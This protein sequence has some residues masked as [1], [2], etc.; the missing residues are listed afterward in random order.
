MRDTLRALLGK[1]GPWGVSSGHVQRPWQVGPGACHRLLCC[2]LWS[3]Q[4]LSSS[5]WVTFYTRKWRV[6]K[7]APHIWHNVLQLPKCFSYL[8][9]DLVLTILFSGKQKNILFDRKKAHMAESPAWHPAAGSP[10]PCLLVVWRE[11]GERRV[12]FLWQAP[13]MARA[14]LPSRTIHGCSTPLLN[15][16]V[17]TCPTGP[18]RCRLLASPPCPQPLTSAH[19]PRRTQEKTRWQVLFLKHKYEHVT[20]L[21]RFLPWLP[22]TTSR[23]WPA[24]Q[25][26]Y[27]ISGVVI[28]AP[29]M[30]C[31]SVL[32]TYDLSECTWEGA[33]LWASLICLHSWHDSHCNNCKNNNNSKCNEEKDGDNNKHILLIVDHQ[34]YWTHISTQIQSSSYHLDLSSNVICSGR[35]F[36]TTF[37]KIVCPP[38]SLPV[39]AILFVLCHSLSHLCIYMVVSCPQSQCH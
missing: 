20:L 18:S 22:R 13:S 7:I 9:S 17:T 24:P 27:W 8:P 35:P 31:A 25:I 10:K 12:L 36:L 33:L 23:V 34:S 38:S 16:S 32:L 4:T 21:P 14:P 3:S 11:V 1:V 5:Y 39:L 28:H 30:L 29:W 15:T 19:S 2:C 26:C 37:Y 6:I